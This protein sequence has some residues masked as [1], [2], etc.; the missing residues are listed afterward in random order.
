M[1][2]VG[3]DLGTTNSLISIWK[4]NKVEL[5][6]NGLGNFMTPSVVGINDDGNILA[7]EVAK[8]RRVSHPKLTAAEFKRTMG[9]KYIYEL[10]DKSYLSEELSA[11]LLKK[12]LSDASQQLGEP[13]TEAVISVPA[14]FDDNQREATKTA[15]EL[16]GVHV[17]RLINE[18]SAAILY[19]QWKKGD[20][21][22]DGICLVVDFGG[23]TLD[24]SVVD[25]FENII[26]IIAVSGD[27]QLGGK[28]FDMALALDFCSKCNLNFNNLSISTQQNILWTAESV[29][30]SLSSQDSAIMH[31]I[32]DGKDY[33][34]TYNNEDFLR[35]TA[36]VLGR[37]KAIINDAING[38]K[39]SVDNI[40]DIVLVG[41]SC[42][43]PI[44]QKY[45][46]ALFHREITA[47]DDIDYCVGYGTGVLTGIIKRE[48]DISDIVMTDVC[49][50]SLGVGTS[51][52]ENSNYYM[53]VII[54]KN[55]ILPTSKTSCYVGLVP[56]QKTIGF[57]IFQGEEMHAKSN[58]QLGRFSIDVE[59]NENGD[60]L[61]E[62]TFRYDINGLLEV[63][64]RD[65]YG[66]N[67]VETTILSKDSR[68]SP[69]EIAAKRASMAKDMRLERDKEENRSI[70][71]WAQ[72]LHA[73]AD[74]EH[75]RL[76]I[77]VIQSFAAALEK[78]S[79]TQIARARQ[80]ILQKLLQLEIL[81]NRNNFNDDNI[82]S[83]LLAD[84]QAERLTKENDHE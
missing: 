26:E 21:G 9:T 37:I 46:S 34:Y 66:T 75:K 10:G 55:T 19:H 72:R 54:P 83:G 4:D 44:V 49:P 59:A 77:D 68:L 64:A 63:T 57:E 11:F 28:D 27:N 15:A 47:A 48:G 20:S 53:S 39:I 38:A 2:L 22:I 14:Y 60:T 5:I 40:V 17:R 32:A 18:P 69:E 12:M 31:I 62:V 43:M 51:N 42:K 29:K 79:A 25:C 84:M 13:I 33:E 36:D 24:I 23:G 82:I 41:G 3:I 56:F 73:Q 71:A 65:V 30:K 1:A 7:G 61:V 35:A 58:L 76:I 78:N 16:A 81:I 50:F 80:Q 67:T 74:E 52:N 45:L 8:N 6:K 70:M